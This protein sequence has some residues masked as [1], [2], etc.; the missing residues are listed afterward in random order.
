MKIVKKENP[1]DLGTEAGKAAAQLIRESIREK[2]VSNVI[3]ATGTSQFDTLR[4]LLEEGIDWSKVNVFHLDEY[5]NLPATHPASFR[6]YLKE[7]FIEKVGQL[8][9]IT[10]I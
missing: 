9:S 3:L 7:R 8:G 5:I 4:Q 2:G 6:K 1:R 10:L